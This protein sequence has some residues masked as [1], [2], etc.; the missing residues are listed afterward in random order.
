MIV[1]GTEPLNPAILHIPIEMTPGLVQLISPDTP[2]RPTSPS[3]W[4]ADDD[5]W[6]TWGTWKDPQYKSKKP[7]WTPHHKDQW[8][9]SSYSHQ[10]SQH[11]RH[12]TLKAAPRSQSKPLTAFS[13]KGPYPLGLPMIIQPQIGI[14]D[15]TLVQ[16]YLQAWS[17]YLLRRIPP[18]NGS[19][20]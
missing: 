13:T 8:R 3:K 17:R 10:Q 12:A 5:D 7:T 18:M 9:Q 16:K 20:M 2:I 6:E 19:T 4:A 11:H 15:P 14:V 1:V